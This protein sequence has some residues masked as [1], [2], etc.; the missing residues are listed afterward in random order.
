MKKLLISLLFLSATNLSGALELG[1]DLPPVTVPSKGELLL[2]GD[3]VN[4]QA[5][6]TEAIAADRPALIFHMAA[7]MSSEAIIDPLRKRLDA[8]PRWELPVHQ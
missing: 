7:R 5:W 1:G 8:L 2:D 4:Y 3:E 6:S